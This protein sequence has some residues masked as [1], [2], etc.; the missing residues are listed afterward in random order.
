MQPQQNRTDKLSDIKLEHRP[1]LLLWLHLASA[2]QPRP[3][4]VI[5]YFNYSPLL[6]TIISA[7]LLNPLKFNV[8]FQ[9][10]GNAFNVQ[11]YCQ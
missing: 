3:T 7:N 2:P 5:L 10:P 6:Q 11:L 8:S 4:V 1:M 9:L